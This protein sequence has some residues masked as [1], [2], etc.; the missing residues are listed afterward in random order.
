MRYRHAVDPKFLFIHT[1]G[2][3]FHW[4]RVPGTNETGVRSRIPDILYS[5]CACPDIYATHHMM[6]TMTQSQLYVYFSYLW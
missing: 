3:M 6:H 1:T 4:T 5:R 2:P